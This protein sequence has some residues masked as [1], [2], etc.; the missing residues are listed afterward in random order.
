MRLGAD[1]EVFLQDK[2]G[3]AISSI[4]YINADK[5]NPMQIPFMPPGFTLQEDNVALEYGIPPAASAQEFVDHIQKV[6]EASKKYLPDLSFS[7]LSCIVF[8]EDQMQTAAAHQFGCEPDFSAWEGGKKN[9]KPKPPHPLMRSAGGHIHV[10]TDADKITVVKLM[11]LYLGVPSV[12]MD[13]GEDRRQLYGGPGCFRPK[14]YGVEYR[15][16]SNFWIFDKKLITWAWNQTQQ[17]LSRA[18]DDIS[19]VEAEKDNIVTCINKGNKDLAWSLCN[20]Y[21]LEVV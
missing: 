15:T 19:W 11:D 1:P 10:E 5:W 4:G 14:S 9:R 17:A 21:N 18:R 6:M 2:N 3:K 13:A 20:A 7:K 8:D 16:L 12:I